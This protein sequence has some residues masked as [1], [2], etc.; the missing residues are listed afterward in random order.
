MAKHG[1]RWTTDLSK[2]TPDTRLKLDEAVKQLKQFTVTKFDQTVDLCVHLGIDPKHADQLVR[3]S[4]SLPH[5]TGKARRVICFC[6]ADKAEAAKGAGAIEAG[7]EELVKKITDGWMEFDVAVASP[8]MMRFVGKL[9]KQLGPRGLMP[10]PKA[11]TVTPDVA[12]AVKEYA[13]GKVNFKNDAGGNVHASI[14]KLSFSEQKL[15]ENAQAFL[16][17][18]EKMKPA[19]T[20]GTYLK[21]ASISGTMTPGV[22]LEV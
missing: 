17:L 7:G 13:A 21:K 16:D 4:V 3:G 6:P 12:T 14:G 2:A 10:S 1:K 9:G 5:G 15:L 22:L 8:D 20:K 19:S 11:G 18:I